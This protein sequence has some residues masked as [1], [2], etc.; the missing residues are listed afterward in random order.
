MHTNGGLFWI[1]SGAL[2]LITK[3]GSSLSDLRSERRLA[4]VQAGLWLGSIIGMLVALGSGQFGGREYW[5]FPPFLALPLFAAWCIFA[6]RFFRLHLPLRPWPV[7]RW[8]WATGIVFFALTLLENYLWL[9]PQ[10]RTSLEADMTLQWKAGGAMVGAWNQMLYGSLLYLATR[11]H[12]ESKAATSPTA[13]ALWLL[14]LFNLM[15]NW[16]HHIYTL[17]T[18]R[19]IKYIAYAVSMTEWILLLRILFQ[20]RQQSRSLRS[21]LHRRSGW[22]IAAA[23]AWVFL[24]LGLALLMSVPAIN[25]YT[26]GTHI[27]VAHA[28][29]AT[30][31]INSMTLLA[32]LSYRR[33]GPEAEVPTSGWK[34][35]FWIAQ[36][37]LL[38]FWLSLLGAGVYKGWH[39]VHHPELPFREVMLAMRPFFIL[40]LSAGSFL[41]A[42]LG[43]ITLRLLLVYKE[44]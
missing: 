18:D 9:F 24:N 2:A 14:G 38:V 11:L 3:A 29:G 34:R 20:W 31:G 5:E 39:Q 44:D 32:C 25:R 42:G 6:F 8:M 12:P 16:G 28:M 22:F 19:L 30:I 1:L 7:Y 23:E 13:Y 41:A 40:F 21:G 4:L 27:T 35:G 36:L 17:P 33:S 37:S 26:H 43:W 15:F 10:V